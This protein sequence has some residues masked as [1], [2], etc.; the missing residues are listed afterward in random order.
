MPSAA[1]FIGRDARAAPH[2][3]S[4]RLPTLDGPMLLRIVVTG[5]PM[6]LVFADRL[7]EDAMAVIERT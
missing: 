1:A 7:V 4:T 6:D 3:V 5:E 2:D